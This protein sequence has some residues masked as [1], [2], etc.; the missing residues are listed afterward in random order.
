MS[1]SFEKWNLA[2]YP[3]PFSLLKFLMALAQHKEFAFNASLG[4]LEPM[5]AESHAM[6]AQMSIVYI[7]S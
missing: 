6:A 2:L 7:S 1:K 4:G 5:D 3:Y